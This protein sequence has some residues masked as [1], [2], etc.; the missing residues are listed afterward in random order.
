MEKLYTATTA[1]ELMGPQDTLATSV[2]GVGHLA[3]GRRWVGNLYLH[4]GGDPD[5]R[6]PPFIGLHYGGVGAT[7]TTLLAA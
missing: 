7:V 6:Q 3:P 2:L 4:G 1:L 5:V